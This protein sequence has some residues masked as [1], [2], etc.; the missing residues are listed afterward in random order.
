MLGSIFIKAIGAAEFFYHLPVAEYQSCASGLGLPLNYF[1]DLGMETAD[2]M[3][4]ACRDATGIAEIFQ[5]VL[6]VGHIRAVD[7]CRVVDGSIIG[8]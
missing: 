5:A 1:D 7:A 3:E 2:A 8:S 6:E 4:S